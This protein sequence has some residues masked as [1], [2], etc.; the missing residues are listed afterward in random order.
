MPR[1]TTKIVCL[2]AFEN[3]KCQDSTE[4]QLNSVYQ[5]NNLNI[6]QECVTSVQGRNEIRTF[7][8]I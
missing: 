2:R 6:E 4:N 7:A 3:D 8:L 1:F 5:D